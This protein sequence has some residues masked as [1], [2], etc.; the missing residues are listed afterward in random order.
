MTTGNEGTRTGDEGTEAAAIARRRV[1]EQTLEADTAAARLRFDDEL[2][3]EAALRAAG[4]ELRRDLSLKLVNLIE[5]LEPYVDSTAGEVTSGLVAVYVKAVQ[6]LGDLYGLRRPP[7]KPGVVL[8][9]RLP[10]PEAVDVPGDAGAVVVKRVAELRGA[11]LLQL[12]AVRERLGRAA[13]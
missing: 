1:W 3:R 9:P 5:S 13:G 11:G 6:A 4:D 2:R 10:E 12:E 8:P 7:S